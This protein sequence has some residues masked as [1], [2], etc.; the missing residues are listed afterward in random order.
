MAGDRTPVIQGGTDGELIGNVADAMKV[1]I[2][3]SSFNPLTAPATFTFVAIDVAVGNN[4]S[5]ISIANTGTEPIF[6][7]SIKILNSQTSAV[8]GV[9]GEFRLLRFATHSGGTAVNGISADTLDTIPVTLTARTGATLSGLNTTP[10]RRTKW[11]TDEWGVGATDVESF[12]HTIQNVF[13]WYTPSDNT[14]PI[15]LRQNEGITV[16]QVVNTTVGTFTLIV[17]VSV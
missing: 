6:L 15:T 7:R 11:S 12:D 10:Y 14:K 13:S 1:N 16:N 17:E 4:K 8:T 9:V 2:V 5:M 3:G